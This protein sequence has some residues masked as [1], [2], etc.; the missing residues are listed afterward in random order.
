[1]RSNTD[2]HNK[3]AWWEGKWRTKGNRG[4]WK[5]E[6]EEEDRMSWRKDEEEE[7]GL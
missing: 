1:M 7:D 2:L 5:E 4:G 3:A 6:E